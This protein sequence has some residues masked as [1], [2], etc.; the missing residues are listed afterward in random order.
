M[1][2][3][4]DPSTKC[5]QLLKYYWWKNHLYTPRIEYFCSIGG[6]YKGCGLRFVRP[7]AVSYCN[8]LDGDLAICDAGAQKVHILNKRLIPVHVIDTGYL[9]DWRLFADLDAGKAVRVDSSPV[10]VAFSPDR[11]LCV[12]FQQGGILV[13][14]PYNVAPVGKMVDFEVCVYCM[15]VF[16]NFTFYCREEYSKNC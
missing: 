1:I 9:P 4:A 6:V 7:N 8:G 2:A 5:V 10:S 16:Q 12:A 13:Y 11:V 3:V 14:K 15:F